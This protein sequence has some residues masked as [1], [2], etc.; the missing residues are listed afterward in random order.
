MARWVARIGEPVTRAD[1]LRVAGIDPTTGTGRT[2][3]KVASERGWIKRGTG[4]AV[5]PGE[6]VP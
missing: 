3:L 4:G 1:A 5:L 6:V 2:I